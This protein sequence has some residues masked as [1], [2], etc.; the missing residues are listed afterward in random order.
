MCI[1]GNCGI[2]F[3]DFPWKFEMVNKKKWIQ[4]LMDNLVGIEKLF[5]SMPN[6]TMSRKIQQKNKEKL[7]F[8]YKNIIFWFKVWEGFVLVE[9]EILQVTFSGTFKVKQSRGKLWT[10]IHKKCEINF[11]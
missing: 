6:K 1:K 11:K 2:K 4:F 8:S 3:M 9:V 10:K 7:G 5:F